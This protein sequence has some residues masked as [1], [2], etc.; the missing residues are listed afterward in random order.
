MDLLTD[1]AQRPQNDVAVIN[2]APDGSVDMMHTDKISL[3]HLGRQHIRRATEIA[4][5]DDTQLWD[6][7]YLDWSEETPRL[8]HRD[9]ANGFAGYEIARQVE[10]KWLTLARLEGVEPLSERGLAHLRQART[11]MEPNSRYAAS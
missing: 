2:F 3:G 9:E 10:V 5:N 7:V 11:V 4:F 6:I 1:I 8:C